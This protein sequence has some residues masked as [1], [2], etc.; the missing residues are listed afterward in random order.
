[1][2]FVTECHPHF[3]SQALT[4][5]S[6][7]FQLLFGKIYKGFDNKWVFL[8]ALFVFEVGSLICAVAPSSVAL[9]VGRAIAGLGSGGIFSGALIIIS[10]LVPL[11]KRPVYISMIGAMFGIASVVGPLV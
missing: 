8:A 9:I 2:W 7:A 11:D 6:T 5:P 4:S 3:T 10:Q 1:M